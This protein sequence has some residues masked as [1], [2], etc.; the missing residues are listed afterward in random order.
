MADANET[1]QPP[2]A[3]PGGRRRRA[4]A[5]PPPPPFLGNEMASAI[6]YMLLMQD[7]TPNL[8]R[9]LTARTKAYY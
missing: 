7:P 4:Y 9:M 6:D 3:S 5:S 2:P 8:L 1:D